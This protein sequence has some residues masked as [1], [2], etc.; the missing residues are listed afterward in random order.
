MVVIW[1]YCFGLDIVWISIYLYIYNMNLIWW[2]PLCFR[3]PNLAYSLRNPGVAVHRIDGYRTSWHNWFQPHLPSDNPARPKEELRCFGVDVVGLASAGTPGQPWSTA[4]ENSPVIKVALKCIEQNPLYIGDAS[5]FTFK[6][7]HFWFI[8]G[9][10]YTYPSE[11][12]E[13]QSQGWHPIYYGKSKMFQTTNQFW[14]SN[15]HAGESLS[16]AGRSRPG[17]W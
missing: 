17:E 13:S 15:C 11:K 8:T 1:W 5:M 4:G 9:W 2:K 7:L 16:L 14:V 3:A 12:Y 10:W 6:H